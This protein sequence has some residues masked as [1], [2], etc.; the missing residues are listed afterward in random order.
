M[1]NGWIF[2]ISYVNVYQAGYDELIHCR[3]QGIDPIGI[4]PLLTI[5]EGSKKHFF[6]LL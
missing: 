3:W 6:Y 1:K 2:P 5:Q 4:D